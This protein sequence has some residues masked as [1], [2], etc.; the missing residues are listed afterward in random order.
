M[1]FFIECLGSPIPALSDAAV[2]SAASTT[3]CYGSCRMWAC[4]TWN[5]AGV[6]SSFIIIAHD[7]LVFAIYAVSACVAICSACFLDVSISSSSLNGGCIEPEHHR[8]VEHPTDT[9]NV[10]DW[11]YKMPEM[12]EPLLGPITEFVHEDVTTANADCSQQ[13]QEQNIS[14]ASVMRSSMQGSTGVV[15]G[16]NAESQPLCD[17][18]DPSLVTP[19][20]PFMYRLSALLGDKSV[21]LFCAKAMLM[22]VC[23]VLGTSCAVLP[24]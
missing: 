20:D 11:S 12:H 1:V 10:H 19:V 4:I 7:Y 24:A 3:G 21:L 6:I 14:A 23:S 16:D 5:T 9:D 18:N 22:G 15:S 8:S 17:W 2:M 13:A